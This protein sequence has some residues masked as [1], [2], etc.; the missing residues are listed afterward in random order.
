MSHQISLPND[1]LF[2]GLYF[3]LVVLLIIVLL[4][5]VRVMEIRRK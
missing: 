1:L 3:G 2:L 4:F 5:A